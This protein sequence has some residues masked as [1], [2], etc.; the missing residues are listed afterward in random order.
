[1]TE[2]PRWCRAFGW[3]VG[4]FIV[5][6]AF[7]DIANGNPP[8]AVAAVN[9]DSSARPTQ[10]ARPS[11]ISFD[12]VHGQFSSEGNLTD[13]QKD[14]AWRNYEGKCVQWT[15]ELTYLDERFFGGFVIGFRH[16][17]D[18]FTYDVLVDAPGSLEE[19][20]LGWVQGSSYTY[21]ATLRS[22]GG[23]I[24]PISADWGCDD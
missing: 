6:I 10:T 11:S 3:V 20:L 2:I 8:S 12:E 4:A 24:L 13:L 7:T 9:L 16:R 1:M 22:Y 18:T 21:T 23:V 5:V 17:R 19:T 14:R 15:G